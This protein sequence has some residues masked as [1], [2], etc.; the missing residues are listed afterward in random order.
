MPAPY[1]PDLR[2]RV[3]H[4]CAMVEGSRA[5]IAQRFA[6]SERSIYLWLEAERAE[7]RT[8]PKP[9]AGGRPSRF[10]AAR[11]RAIHEAQPDVTLAECAV[12]YQ[13]QTGV[14]ISRS[15]VERL[16]QELDLRRKKK[17]AARR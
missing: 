2:R 5:Q 11:V 8:A 3:L 1:S 16:L 10:D 9:H 6:V 7:G 17:D 4:A 14:P 13:T 15:S 12:R